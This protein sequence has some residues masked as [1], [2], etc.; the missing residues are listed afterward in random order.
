MASGQ[1]H[2]LLRIEFKDKG[3]R[4]SAGLPLDFHSSVHSGGA[5]AAPTGATLDAIPVTGL[6]QQAGARLIISFVT[7]AA[8][9][10]ESE[11]S[12][13]EIPVLV[14]D[15]KTKAVVGRE[16]IK[17]EAMTGFKP[18][19]TV[20]TVALVAGVP[21]RLAYKDV[22]EG[23]AYMLDPNGKVRFYMGDDA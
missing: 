21:Y 5:L 23:F 20:D 2:G 6:V 16:T 7:D 22:A 18:S 4:L 15:P 10:I 13:C 17:L 12:D 3:E 9:I 14:I 8:D 19:G 11:E 1:E